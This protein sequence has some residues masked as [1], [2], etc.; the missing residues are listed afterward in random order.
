MIRFLHWILA[1][2]LVGYKNTG[3]RVSARQTISRRE[4]EFNKSMF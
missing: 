1:T 2:N 3:F 4:N